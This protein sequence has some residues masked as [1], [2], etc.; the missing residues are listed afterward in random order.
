MDPAPDPT[1]FFI[2]FKDARKIIY[3]L[4]T[5]PQA[6]HL[7]SKKFIFLL[8]VCAENF[9]LPALFQFAK[10]IYEKREDSGAGSGSAPLICGSGS[11]T[12]P[13]T[14]P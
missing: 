4:T 11:P 2:H 1:S 14:N 13:K 3:F 9:I 6:H 12:L 8:K 10:H 7:Q 5:C